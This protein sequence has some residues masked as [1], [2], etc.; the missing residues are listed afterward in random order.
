MDGNRIGRCRH[1][2]IFPYFPHGRRLVRVL[3]RAGILLRG[4]RRIR[5]AGQRLARTG[6]HAPAGPELSACQSS[7]KDRTGR[8]AGAAGRKTFPFQPDVQCLHGEPAGAETVQW[9]VYD[10]QVCLGPEG[11]LVGNGFRISGCP[12]RRPDPCPDGGP[13]CRF[14]AADR[15]SFLYGQ[16]AEALCAGKV[17]CRS[18]PGKRASGRHRGLGARPA[19]GSERVDAGKRGDPR[20]PVGR[21]SN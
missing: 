6:L 5:R 14:T 7:G 9:S 12:V 2:D 20:N 21:S 13:E 16:C 15:D 10:G 17:V 19:G 8:R 4:C 3:C 18:G 1:S 11:I